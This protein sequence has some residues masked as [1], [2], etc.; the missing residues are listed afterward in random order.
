MTAVCGGGTS[1]EKTGFGAT[2]ALSAPAI[3]ALLNNIPTAWA[4]PLAGYI[5]LVTYELVTYCAS[6]PPAVPTITAADV[7]ALFTFLD[8]IG[9]TA[10]VAKFEQ[11]IGAFLWFDVCKCDSGATPTIPSPPAA[12]TGMPSIN[13]PAIGPAYPTGSVCLQTAQSFVSTSADTVHQLDVALPTGATTVTVTFHALENVASTTGP[14]ASVFFK[15][16]GGSFVGTGAATGASAGGAPIESATATVPS[17]AVTM[18]ME[19]GKSGSWTA[20][21]TVHV[22][23]TWSVN[24]GS[25]SGGGTVPVPCP[26]DPYA[27]ALMQEIL[28][29]VRLIQR[30]QVPFAYI[31]STSHSG[32]TGSGSIAVQG[33]LGMAL[34]LTI[35]GSIVGAEDGNPDFLWDAGWV[36]WGGADGV[37]PRERLTAQDQISLPALGGQFTA[38]HYSLP[39]GVTMTAQELTREP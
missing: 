34:H 14:F 2:L 6:D 32:L 8:P 25:G 1:S 38:F 39:L 5:G 10:A 26:T 11:L 17:T 12:P 22:D 13:P 23:A 35:T 29:L 36:N 33:L 20:P 4:A 16:A 30:Q 9:H 28:G 7:A 37:T 21:A 27:M 31:A 24:C 18:N 3:A 15:N 19:W